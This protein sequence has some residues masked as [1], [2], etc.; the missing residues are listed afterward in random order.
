MAYINSYG[1]YISMHAWESVLKHRRGP[2]AG[3][4]FVVVD[5]STER[6]RSSD[7]K[8]ESETR[9]A[10]IPIN[11]FVD[12]GWIMGNENLLNL[13]R[14]YDPQSTYVCLFT[15]GFEYT[16]TGQE[17]PVLLL[18]IDEQTKREVESML[19]KAGVDLDSTA[20]ST[21][22]EKKAEPVVVDDGTPKCAA[23]GRKEES[24]QDKFPVCG[25]CRQA[26]VARPAKYCSREC[27]QK[28]W[29]NHKRVCSK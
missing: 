9:M 10:F 11:Q 20:A 3:R 13:V 6:D 22:E 27:Q 18:S 1:P 5:L 17:L 15:D 14:T 12:H 25:R 29:P 23:C 4:G 16:E 7:P 26:K 24:E 28:D 8:E 19:K 2:G 21:K